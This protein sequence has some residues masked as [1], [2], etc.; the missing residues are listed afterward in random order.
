MATILAEPHRNLA[1]FSR[2]LDGI[3]QQVPD[4][5]LDARRVAGNRS[6]VAVHV[7]SDADVPVV[8]VALNGIDRVGDDRRHVHESDLESQL[9]RDDPAD[10]EQ[11]RDQ[12]RLKTRV[13][14][15]DLEPSRND[16]RS[17]ALFDHQLR[18]PEDRI[19]RRPELVRDHRHEFVFH[20]ARAFGVRSCGALR[21]QQSVAFKRRIVAFELAATAFADVAKHQYRADDSAIATANRCAAVVDRPFCAIGRNQHGM[22]RQANDRSFGKDAHD[23]TVHGPATVLVDDVEDI[24]A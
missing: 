17:G 23:W 2:E 8:R 9:A 21:L 22:V 6:D 15:D 16:F 14:A 7:A 4:D 13:T 12:L 24:C 3:G 19:Q 5:L 1:S 10:I 20:T 18:P 11:V